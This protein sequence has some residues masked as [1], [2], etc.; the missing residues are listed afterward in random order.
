MSELLMDVHVLQR[1]PLGAFS[2]FTTVVLGVRQSI[3]FKTLTLVFVGIGK[4]RIHHSHDG[5][6]FDVVELELFL[7]EPLVAIQNVALNQ[8]LGDIDEVNVVQDQSL[9]SRERSIE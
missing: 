2:D 5:Q 6:V 3:T 1:V 8:L 4:F 7:P 9:M